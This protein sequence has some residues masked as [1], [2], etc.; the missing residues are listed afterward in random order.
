MHWTRAIVAAVM[1]MLAATLS[2]AT[3]IV[4]TDEELVAK[5]AAIVSGTVE[6]SYVQRGE[7]TIETVYEIRIDRALKGTAASRG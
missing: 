5:S 1:L 2:A 3:F 7:S 6:G 4:P